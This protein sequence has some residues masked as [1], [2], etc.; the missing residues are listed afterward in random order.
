MKPFCCFFSLRLTYFEF[1]ICSGKVVFFSHKIY[2]FHVGNFEKGG[3]Y[4]YYT[5]LEVVIKR[6]CLTVV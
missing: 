1:Q 2:G 4:Q 3:V 5:F 6:K